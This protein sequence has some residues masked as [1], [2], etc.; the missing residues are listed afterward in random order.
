MKGFKV[1]FSIFVVPIVFC[2]SDLFG[3]PI[4]KRDA[5]H[6]QQQKVSATT[7]RSD[8]KTRTQ[9]TASRLKPSTEKKE[10]T[11][12]LSRT[13]TQNV[14]TATNPRTKSVISRADMTITKQ[15][16]KTE[17]KNTDRNAV[18]K[19][20][21]SRATRTP[22]VSRNTATSQVAEV[23]TRNYSKCRTVYNDCMD[24][25]CATK[26]TQLKRC[27]CSV[28]HSEFKNVKVSLDAAEEKMLDFSQRLLVV[29]M[30]KEDAQAANQATEGEL[31]YYVKDS[32]ESKKLLDE[33]AKKLDSSFESSNIDH[34][35]SAI[36]L[37]LN[38]NAAFDSIDSM[39]G[40]T[41]TTKI[42]QALYSAALPVC[43]EMA[44]EVCSAEELDI[45]ESS[46]QLMIEQDCNTVS[47]TYQT[48]VD[49]ARTKILESNALL[50]M[51]RLD[52]HQKRNS[53]DILTCKTKM[54]NM[55]TDSAVCGEDL[56]KCLDTT[57]H[58]INP[59]TGQAIL[60]P[61]LYLLQE[62]ITRPT[63]ELSW[64]TIP[65]NANFVNYLNT[66]KEY[67]KPAMENCQNISDYV[68]DEFLDDALAKIKLA[69]N[70]K[71]EEV[72]QSCTTLI[73]EC[74]DEANKTI[75]DFD[76]RALSVFGISADK[77]ATEMCNDVQ[78]TCSVL[79]DS[80]DTNS[81]NW[82]DGISGL[83]STKTYESILQNC[84]TIG[85]D[86][87]V[88]ACAA[89]SGNFD[90]CKDNA[91]TNR[92]TILNGKSCWAEVQNC[93]NSAGDDALTKIQTEHP[94][95]NGSFYVDTYDDEE[96]TVYDLCAAICDEESPS[97]DCY[98]CRLTE[99]IWGNCQQAPATLTETN[100]IVIPRN[101]PTAT[102][103]AW[104]A[105]NT[106]T[107]SCD[108]YISTCSGF[109]YI[110]DAIKNCCDTTIVN[111]NGINICCDTDNTV[112]TVN[113]SYFGDTNVAVQNATN[114]CAP[115]VGTNTANL[116]Y[117]YS[118][119][120]GGRSIATSTYCIGEVEEASNSNSINCIGKL[121]KIETRSSG[122]VRFYQLDAYGEFVPINM[123]YIDN[124]NHICTYYE[125]QNGSY[126]WSNAN[127]ECSIKNPTGFH[128]YYN[129]TE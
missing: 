127:G 52:I 10:R 118:T 2:T 74:I 99:R 18:E 30:D 72:R 116:I 115:L 14:R 13:A 23:L 11:N 62:T 32:S 107:Q 88:R 8:T 21:T 128:L 28:R 126:G 56:F 17:N 78:T 54:L 112:M 75:A 20:I 15:T 55:L 113:G 40:A 24:E 47:K 105:E 87:I 129:E 43:R 64:T 42:G 103:L 71:I 31:A 92:A 26:D 90:L 39:A 77:T 22:I 66:K 114:I 33:I 19:K 125:N 121:I 86:C 95:T 29:N 59:A 6:R 60:T 83:L 69:Q 9:N 123:T 68:W 61:D 25:F 44:A 5:T 36:S 53:D 97:L 7:H 106:G 46:Y 96:L 98:K 111:N 80:I 82:G 89:S 81:N 100:N 38:T 94:L 120:V 63:G 67:L 93:I 70:A 84:R 3:V 12:V 124:K 45:A 1:L 91:S 57:G 16:N 101:N 109:I 58:F 104:L 110:S 49:Q 41:T 51:S 119:V 65:A 34:N 108:A 79:I 48:Q 37:S 27:A 122:L 50:D 4:Q 102:L 76:A 117:N 85:E 35:L 73:T